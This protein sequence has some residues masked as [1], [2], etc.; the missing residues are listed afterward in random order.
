MPNNAEDVE[1]FTLTNERM[2]REEQTL[3]QRT[4]YGAAH[5][6]E[7]SIAQMVVASDMKAAA[8]L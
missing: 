6:T 2:T 3:G 8:A 7:E 4:P 5:P 1:T